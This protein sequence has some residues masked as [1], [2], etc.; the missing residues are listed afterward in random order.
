MRHRVRV[1]VDR[2]LHA[3]PLGPQDVLV[4]QVQPVGIGVDLQRGA[5]AGAAREHLVQV[6]VDRRPLADQAGRWGGR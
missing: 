4:A 2:E 5:G 6:D 1:G 3:V